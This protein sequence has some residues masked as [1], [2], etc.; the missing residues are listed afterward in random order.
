MTILFQ[1]FA[2]NG[3]FFDLINKNKYTQGGKLSK[4]EFLEINNPNYFIL[5]FAEI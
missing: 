3:Y 5:N 1:N 2:I 4:N